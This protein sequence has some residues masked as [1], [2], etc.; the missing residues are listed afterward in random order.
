MT[1]V[2]CLKYVLEQE[3]ILETAFSYTVHTVYITLVICQ[4]H[5][6]SVKKSNVMCFYMR[7][8]IFEIFINR[9]CH[10]LNLCTNII[11]L[12]CDIC[13]TCITCIWN[14]FDLL[15]GTFQALKW[16][17][18]NFWFQRAIIS[19]LNSRCDTSLFYL[20]LERTWCDRTILKCIVIV[21]TKMLNA[22]FYVLCIVY[23][24][25]MCVNLGVNKGA[26]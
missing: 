12:L 10:V 23:L 11:V 3:G 16:H 8:F 20:Y 15:A 13:I 18:E 25:K 26:G 17:F 24:W 14:A 4:C 6:M 22:K 7:A 1:R 21:D 19:T 2:L 5:W 9:D